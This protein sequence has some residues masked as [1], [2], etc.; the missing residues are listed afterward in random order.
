MPATIWAD[1]SP[2][3]VSGWVSGRAS[4]ARLA[5]QAQKG[6]SQMN[7]VPIITLGISSRL[8]I[9]RSSPTG[10]FRT[11]N[12]W[13]FG[14][15]EQE[16]EERLLLPFLRDE[17]HARM[18]AERAAFKDPS[19]ASPQPVHAGVAENFPAVRALMRRSRVG[20]PGAEEGAIGHDHRRGR[21]RYVELGNFDS[22]LRSLD[23]Q[24]DL[25]QVQGLAGR[26]SGFLDA[27]AVNERAVGGSTVAHHDSLVSEHDLAMQL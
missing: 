9:W 13:Q 25:S 20:M 6:I 4:C 3:R 11:A 22:N 5:T 27:F 24:F 26:Q 17:R 1:R 2:W 16:V 7:R 8:R 21:A 10:V 15:P 18:A 23:Q 12:E 14:G 19:S